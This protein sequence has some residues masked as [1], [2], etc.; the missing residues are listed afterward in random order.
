MPKT[1]HS[2]KKNT[3]K[4]ISPKH[5]GSDSALNKDSS[6]DYDQDNL[7]N[8][9]KR[10]KRRL[11]E[12]PGSCD[13]NVENKIDELRSYQEYKFEILTTAISTLIEQ[14]SEIKK[15]VEF[16][17]AQYDSL[18]NKVDILEKDNTR[19]KS[20]IQTLE[21]KL[22]IIERTSRSTSIEIRNFPIIEKENKQ[23]L[24]SSLKSISEIV[25]STPPLQDLEVRD[26]HRTKSSSIVVDLTTTARRDSL[27][28]KYRD[29]NKSQ[30]NI[31]EPQLNTQ[32]L[33]LPGEVKPIF[34]S[35]YLTT[36]IRQIFYLARQ[37]V[38]NKK[39]FAAWTSYGKVYVRKEEGK[40]VT[41]LYNEGDLQ[42][43]TSI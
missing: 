21:N 5:Y 31:K 42:K 37:E 6:T 40:A 10:L 8:I 3:P 20:Q 41:R 23:V 39:L 34:I 19:Y 27:I 12:T 16:M 4:N 7:L 2:P 22:D 29:Y 33:S 9:T 30:R 36:K 38:K 14:N 13:S 15:S 32:S 24:T 35:E 11:V 43:L 26:I 18:I 28:S 1:Q 17:S 25:K